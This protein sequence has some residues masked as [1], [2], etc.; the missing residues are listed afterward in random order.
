MRA[1]RASHHLTALRRIGLATASLA[2]ASVTARV[3]SSA[4][5]SAV[6][7]IAK[8]DI[9]THLLTLA[10]PGMEGR[11]S[12][13]EG[14]R[15]AAEYI[16]ERFR[17]AGLVPTADALELQRQHEEPTPAPA[18]DAPRTQAG[19]ACTF[20]RP[21]TLPLEGPDVEACALT[22]TAGTETHAFRC[23]TDFVPVPTCVGEAEGPLV[24]AGFGI[25]S[26]KHK[27]DDLRGLDLRDK[28]VLVFEGEP[29]HKSK[30]EGDEFTPDASMWQKLEHLSAEGAAAV[31]VVRRPPVGGEE[32]GANALDFRYTYASFL[33]EGEPRV[34]QSRPPV[35]DISIACATLLLGEDAAALAAKLDRSVKP[36]KVALDGRVVKLRSAT[37]RDQVRLDN[38]VG[39]VP[40]SDETLASEFVVLGAHYDHIG[41]DPRGR[42][43]AGA[44]DNASGT[45]AL[46]A[47][48]GA[49]MEAKPRRSILVCAFAAEED[50]L[51]GSKEIC[52]R[53]PVDAAKVV[54]MVNLDMVGRGDVDEVAVLG[55]KQNP[56]LEK[57]L[58]RAKALSRTGVK[59]VV[60]GKGEDLW[61]RSDHYSFHEIGI[62]SLFFFEGLPIS[63]NPDYHTWRDVPEF[64]DFEKITRTARLVF[65]TVWI[66]ANDD[67]RPPPPT[68]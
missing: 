41:V 51:V 5:A 68:R 35:L 19:A 46:L 43:G 15:R 58:D 45:S 63:R 36:T 52:K 1:M 64:I 47:L 7:S 55:T 8:Q 33:G 25:S 13:S 6:A 26:K 32:D 9:E 14:Q 10:A 60:T 29:R 12:P 40:G 38:V 39:V 53:L 50:G 22:L 3:A 34:P 31:L 17:E 30:F 61:L 21:F 65:N 4:D 2:L 11:D 62:P 67:E 27:Y 66:L 56:E 24:F 57:V 20:L 28:V 37:R 54:A 44:D 16:C 23:G 48:A 18:D 42:V 49:L 59:N